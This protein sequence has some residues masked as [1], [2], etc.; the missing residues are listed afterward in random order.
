M[1]N[2][3]AIK[4]MKEAAE[5]LQALSLRVDTVLMEVRRLKWESHPGVAPQPLSAHERENAWWLVQTERDQ[6]GIVSLAY[7]GPFGN[8]DALH[9]SPLYK[10]NSGH[11]RA[12]VLH[13]PPK[14]STP[15]SPRT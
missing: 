6:R 7:W 11:Q 2:R 8:L 4:A 14:S 5:R 9:S 13:N 15:A 12:I 3:E 10:P 1:R